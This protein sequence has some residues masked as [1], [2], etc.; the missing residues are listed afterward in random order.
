MKQID[1]YITEKLHL[2]K[3]ISICK[4]HKG[5]RF[6]AIS[7]AIRADEI[8][9]SIHQPFTVLQITDTHIKYETN[10]GK[11]IEHK[12]FINSNGFIEI[13]PLDTMSSV[14]MTIEDGIHY[15]KNCILGRGSVQLEMFNYFDKED[16]WIN[17]YELYKN[18]TQDSAKE[19]LKELE[20]EDLDED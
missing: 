2:N 14:F 3:D 19:L 20:T 1:L 9:L 15:I 17:D 8:S 5:D 10:L 11:K 16:E 12:Y 13:K 6:F 18:Y 7:A 4:L